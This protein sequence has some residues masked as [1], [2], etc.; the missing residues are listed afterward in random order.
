MVYVLDFTSFNFDGDDPIREEIV[1]TLSLYPSTAMEQLIDAIEMEFED[2]R[3][4]PY[5]DSQFIV[6]EKEA[7]ADWE[8]IVDYHATGPIDIKTILLGHISPS[9]WHQV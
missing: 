9:G 1:N 5:P 2:W 4:S 7:T 6:N 3:L 8:E